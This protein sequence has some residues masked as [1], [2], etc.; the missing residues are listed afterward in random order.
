MNRRCLLPFFLLPLSLLLAACDF[1]QNPPGINSTP[2]PP[3]TAPPST[4][5]PQVTPVLSGSPT[6][7]PA[8]SPLRV[9][10]PPE[11]GAR[12]EAGSE[13]LASQ[14]RAFQTAHPDLAV[15][16]EQKPVD[17]PGGILSY[18]QT[19]RDVAPGVMPDVA[20]VPT[21][22][23]ADS[24]AQELFF[25]L[26][27]LID[28]GL[29]ADVYP[30]AAEQV[31]GAGRLM[32]Y[33]FATVGLSN[34]IYQPSVIT[35]TIPMN[36]SRLIS[37]TNHTL[38]FPADSREGAMLGLQLYLAEGGRLADDE[39]QPVLETEPLSRALATIGVR[40]ENL[41]QSHQLK[42]LDEAW[43][44]HQLGLS[45]FMW[46]R[47]EHLLNLQTVDPSLIAGQS[48][49]AV[50]GISGPLV[51]LTTSWAWA[52]TTDDPARQVQAADLILSLTT[53]ENLANW[54]DRSHVL[55][56]RRSAMA[57]LAAQ[58]PYY[59]FAGEQSE[60]A[61]PMPVSETSRLLDVL[62]DAVFQV[63]TTEISPVLIAEQAATA[64]RQ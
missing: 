26:D 55:P 56:A 49:S 29:I 31:T 30:A 16:I 46:T 19:G 59:E 3:V 5:E 51:P 8:T 21:S 2:S 38:V 50:P 41:L 4:A 48:Y 58:N 18:L 6:Q 9:W 13:E 14:I 45:D 40:R 34:L 62:G 44:Y 23:L 10:I 22:L 15:V 36:W 27:Q 35:G 12:T 32:G 43:Q 37:D 28:S 7:T 20:A 64:L 57:T 25:P 54:S 60:R 11:I 53:P 47:A 52:I 33:P 1:S 17:G 39:G 42:T 61:R 63:L 24:R